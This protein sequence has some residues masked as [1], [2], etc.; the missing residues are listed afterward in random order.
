MG[1]SH[2]ESK[3]PQHQTAAQKDNQPTKSKATNQPRR[4]EPKQEENNKA[5]V[6]LEVKEPELV[7]ISIP[8]NGG[9]KWEKSF[10]KGSVIKDIVDEYKKDNQAEFNG[11]NDIVWKLNQNPMN[12]DAKLESVIPKDNSNVDLNIEYEIIG[13]PN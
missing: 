10:S 9:K 1:C 11:N 7:K 13:L 3:K 8:V 5:T 6:N 12:L 4:E 2:V